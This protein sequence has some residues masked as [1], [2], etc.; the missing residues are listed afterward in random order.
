MSPNA[1]DGRDRYARS[2]LVTLVVAV[3]IVGAVAGVTSPVAGASGSVARGGGPAAGALDDGGSVAATGNGATIRVGDRRIAVG[4]TATVPVRLSGLSNGTAGYTIRIDVSDPSNVTITEVQFPDGSGLTSAEIGAGNATARIS[5]ADTGGRIQPGDGSAVL[6]RLEVVGQSTGAADLSVSPLRVTDDSGGKITTTTRNGTVTVA[7]E[8]RVIV[9]DDGDGDYASLAR[10]LR[11]VGDGYTVVVRN[12]TYAGSVVVENNVTIRAASDAV[13]DGSSDPDGTGIRIA[14]GSHAAPVIRG[15]TVRGFENGVGIDASGT[16]GDWRIENV[17]VEN[18]FVGVAA[19]FDAASTIVGSKPGA[20]GDWTIANSTIAGFQSVTADGATGDWTIRDSELRGTLQASETTGRFRVANTTVADAGYGIDARGATGAFVV[21]HTRIRNA[22]V[23]IGADGTTG[24]WLVENVSILGGY[25]GLRAENAEGAWTVVNATIARTGQYGVSAENTSGAWTIRRSAVAHSG[26]PGIDAARSDGTGVVRRSVV[27][28][29]GGAG[30]DATNAT[31]TVNATRNWWGN[32]SGPTEDQ[33]VGNVDCGNPLSAAPVPVPPATTAPERTGPR[34]VVAPD[35]S[36]DYG[37]IRA[38]IDN[39]SDN[40]T[41]VV[42]SGT[43][44]ATGIVIDKNVTIVGRPGATVVGDGPGSGQFG[45]TPAFVINRTAAPTIRGLALEDHVTG[46]DAR[47]TVGDW[48]ARN[49]TVRNTRL[50]LHA[51][52]SSGD[53]TFRNV[54]HR[55]PPGSYSVGVYAIRT[56]GDWRVG[57]FETA[58]VRVGVTAYA[59][60]GAWTVTAS[61]FENVSIGVL[62]TETSGAWRVTDTAVAANPGQSANYNAT[63]ID[64]AESTGPW[65]VADVRVTGATIGIDGSRGS[66]TVDNNASSGDWRVERAVLENN[67]IAIDAVA[68]N[69]SWTVSGSSITGNDRGIVAANASPGGDAT[70]NWWG[71]DSGPTDDQ[72]VGNVDCGSPLSSPPAGAGPDEGPDGAVASSMRTSGI[73]GLPLRDA[74]AEPIRAAPRAYVRGAADGPASDLETDAVRRRRIGGPDDDRLVAVAPAADGDG[75]V[76]VGTTQSSGPGASAVWLLRVSADGEVLFERTYGGGG[77]EVGLGVLTLS[78]GYLIVGSTTSFGGRAPKAMGIRVGTDGRTKWLRAYGGPRADRAFAA[79]RTPTGF[80]LVGETRSFGNGS[81]D[82]FVIRTDESG[83][84]RS[85]RTFGGSGRDA[86][87]DVTAIGSDE[88]AMAGVRAGKDGWYL[89]LGSPGAPPTGSRTFDR[90]PDD[91]LYAIASTPDGPLLTGRTDRPGG[92]NTEAWV[93]ALN[94]SDATRWIETVGG[95]GNDRGL[96]IARRGDRTLLVGETLSF[97]ANGRDGLVSEIT[98][99]G[100]TADSASYDGGS[101]DRFS[102]LVT[103]PGGVGVVGR[104]AGTGDD[105]D[106]WLVVGVESDGGGL[107]GGASGGDADGDE[108][109]AAASPPRQVVSSTPDTATTRV[110]TSPTPGGSTPLTETGPVTT[111]ETVGTDATTSPAGSTGAGET[112]GTGA[113]TPGF[114][115]PAGGTALLLG[116][117]SAARWK[118]GS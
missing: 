77:S 37:S 10:A 24:D 109:T 113:A 99:D 107:D 81:T 15:L 94:G 88:Y 11:N 44:D 21:S 73:A 91:A 5:V 36:G 1:P 60:E 86:F 85:N 69:G 118:A 39:A 2:A 33:C 42:R 55:P 49:L 111:A 58:D 116:A 9:N 13:V 46:I 89:A 20:S 23:G 4:R 68:A 29:N 3:A 80:L 93:I 47:D 74:A 79:A 50:A 102:D 95:D 115:L 6:A 106:G 117:L 59:A 98:S 26:G 31:A 17:T 52:G 108:T 14:A 78:N 56:T 103:V 82:G 43:Y 16:T 65:T 57:R 76:A 40:A 34:V 83:A 61:R 35:G 7:G 18:T 67:G 87:F 28:G 8:A 27:V 97:G 41:I 105:T 45:T 30:V 110:A 53:W 12:G 92:G 25:G 90:T 22:V 104:T 75:Y 114:G 48:S 19:G 96:G 101:S 54:T 62:A 72:C 71:R 63:G 64:A 66:I 38:A 70:G 100:R 84:E 32:A 112:N 51:A